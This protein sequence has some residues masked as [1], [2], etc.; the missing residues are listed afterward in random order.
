MRNFKFFLALLLIYFLSRCSVGVNKDLLTGLTYSYKGLSLE[1]AYL[2][3]D[4][5]KLKT[6]EIEYGERVNIILSGVKGY[7]LDNGKVEIGCKIVVSD[8]EGNAVISADDVFAASYEGGLAPEDAEVLSTALTVG[9]PLEIGK[10]Y[11]WK[12]LFWDKNG[13][14][15]INTEIKIK[16]IPMNE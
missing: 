16:I 12:S 10:E 2:V 13:K 7:E 4:N 6:N 1:D 3:I 11:T 9:K 14:G 5:I 15:T 8:S